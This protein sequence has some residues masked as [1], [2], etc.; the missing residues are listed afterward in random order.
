MVSYLIY[1]QPV[2]ITLANRSNYLAFDNRK[3]TVTFGGGS[4]S[5]NPSDPEAWVSYPLAIDDNGHTVTTMPVCG[6]TTR[7]LADSGGGPDLSVDRTE[8]PNLS[9]RLHVLS[10]RSE[11]RPTWGD[12]V[13]VDIYEVE[14][15][16]VGVVRKKRATIMV[17]DQQGMPVVAGLGVFRD[18]AVVF[19]F[20]KNKLWVRK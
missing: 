1:R 18:T 6:V 17:S 10:R 20:Q 8:W 19:D 14:N 15:L 9:R 13:D 3:Q 12:F 4:A 11:K 7:V 5:F 16:Q 2:A